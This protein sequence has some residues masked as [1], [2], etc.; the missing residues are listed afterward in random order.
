MQM[1]LRSSRSDRWIVMLMIEA[2]ANTMIVLLVITFL[3]VVM[4]KVLEK[5]V[6]NSF[7]KIARAEAAQLDDQLRHFLD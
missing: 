7:A 1:A 5:I 2:L 3:M 6:E 4:R